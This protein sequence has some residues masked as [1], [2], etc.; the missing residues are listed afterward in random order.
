MKRDGV[1]K[2]DNS[3]AQHTPQLQT[4]CPHTTKNQSESEPGR[5]LT[6]WRLERLYEYVASW[7]CTIYPQVLIKLWHHWPSW[8]GESLY[9]IWYLSTGSQMRRYW[10]F[11]PI[12][13]IPQAQMH[14]IYWGTQDNAS[15]KLGGLNGSLLLRTLEETFHL[16]LQAITTL[17]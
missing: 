1:E 5:A 16:S 8:L 9:E 15:I 17:F 4:G 2:W 11:N 6:S 7:P 14:W 10:N 13:W 12:Q 3:Q